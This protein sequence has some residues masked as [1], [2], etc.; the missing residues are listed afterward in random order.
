MS[1]CTNV[2][3]YINYVTKKKTN[4]FIIERKLTSLNAEEDLI[5]RLLYNIDYI[6][7]VE[8]VSGEID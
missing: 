8:S 5:L 4:N 3:K 2:Q 6:P 1:K 7:V